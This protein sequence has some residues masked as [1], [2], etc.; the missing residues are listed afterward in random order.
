MT[1][2]VFEDVLFLKV[3]STYWNEYTDKEAMEK[4]KSEN[5][6]KRLKEDTQHQ[7]LAD[8]S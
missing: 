4:A 6:Q 8:I 3:K 5:V 2:L 1:P 7:Q